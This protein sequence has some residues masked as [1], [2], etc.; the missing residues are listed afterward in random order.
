MP[1]HRR[2]RQVLD[3]QGL[4]ADLAGSHRP[5]DGD[6]GVVAG[7]GVQAGQGVVDGDEA[8]GVR[9]GGFGSTG[10]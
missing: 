5:L 9:T 4:A 7:L 1:G 8:D 10:Q 3:G 6:A 2:P